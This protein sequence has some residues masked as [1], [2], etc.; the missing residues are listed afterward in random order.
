MEAAVAG[1]L[2]CLKYPGQVGANWSCGVPC[3]QRT[4]ALD[5]RDENL[6]T[7]AEGSTYIHYVSF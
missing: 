5:G 6:S 1:Q 4:A 3:G 2:H 7:P